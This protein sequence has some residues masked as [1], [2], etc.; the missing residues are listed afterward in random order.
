MNMQ[1]K[2]TCNQMYFI[3]LILEIRENSILIIE[4]EKS[5]SK[6]KEKPIKYNYN[7]TNDSWTITDETGII[8]NFTL[9]STKKTDS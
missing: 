8:Y 3:F 2:G 6:K 5:I 1:L 9:V 4:Q 7:W